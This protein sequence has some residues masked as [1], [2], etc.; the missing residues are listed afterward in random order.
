M[1]KS[2]F[3]KVLKYGGIS[4]HFTVKYFGNLIIFLIL[5][6]A[7]TLLC[8]RHFSIVSASILKEIPITTSV[9]KVIAPKINSKV[10]LSFCDDYYVKDPAVFSL[11]LREDNRKLGIWAFNLFQNPSGEWVAVRRIDDGFQGL[12]TCGENSYGNLGKKTVREA[13]LLERTGT[14]NYKFQADFLEEERLEQI[15]SEAYKH[16]PKH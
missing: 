9:Q 15:F 7:A 10:T 11:K 6:I 1:D 8:W 5:L 16:F 3:N 12:F 4:F 14:H 2:F 13:K